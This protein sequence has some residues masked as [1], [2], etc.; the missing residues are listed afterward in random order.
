MINKNVFLGHL[1]LMSPVE[2]C[3]CLNSEELIDGLLT[4]DPDEQRRFVD[5]FEKELVNIIQRYQDIKTSI[6]FPKQQ[7]IL[8]EKGNLGF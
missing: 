8:A 7:K 5:A 4:L 6:M 1:R 3:L 2:L